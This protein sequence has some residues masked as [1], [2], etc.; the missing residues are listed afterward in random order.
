MQGGAPVNN[1]RH[2]DGRFLPGTS[3]NPFG[4][5][6]G[7]LNRRTL[8]TLAGIEAAR[9]EADSPL[10]AMLR[11]MDYF[12]RRARDL[13]ASEP[14]PDAAGERERQAQISESF[15][16]AALI[17][18]MAAPYLHARLSP[19]EIV[20]PAPTEEREFVFKLNLGEPPALR[21]AP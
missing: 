2:Q 16:S 12:D 11:A 9:G 8:A 21:S 18:R 20:A 3:G 1:S 4:R 14:L 15:M 10:A 6:R 5:P 13:L 19:T 17:A 7:A